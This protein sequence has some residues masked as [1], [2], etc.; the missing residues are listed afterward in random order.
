MSELNALCSLCRQ[1][2]ETEEGRDRE[3]QDGHTWDSFR[4]ALDD[5]CYICLQTWNRLKSSVD[6]V[7]SPWAGLECPEWMMRYSYQ[8]VD[9]RT[10]VGVQCAYLGG[11]T[12]IGFEVN[13]TK[14]KVFHFLDALIIEPFPRNLSQYALRIYFV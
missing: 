3:S 10:Y 13:D 5:S 14:S 12:E 11:K 7:P 4:K 6:G 9:E 1:I 8:H 2:L